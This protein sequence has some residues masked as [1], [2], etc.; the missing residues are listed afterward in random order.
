MRVL[1]ARLLQ[2]TYAFNVQLYNEN[3]QIEKHQISGQATGLQ[4]GCSVYAPRRKVALQ[5]VVTLCR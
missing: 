5:K 1:V 2:S 4:E 3:M